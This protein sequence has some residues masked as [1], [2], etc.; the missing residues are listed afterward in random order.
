[1]ARVTIEAVSPASATYIGANLR[2]GDLSEMRAVFGPNVPVQEMAYT[3]ADR[4]APWSYTAK[5]DGQPVM[6]FGVMVDPLLPHL[7]AAWGFGTRHTRRVIPTVTRFIKSELIPALMAH[8]L[9][10]VEV[11]AEAKHIEA[12]DWIHFDL[13]ARHEAQLVCCGASG[14]DFQQLSWTRKPT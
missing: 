1:M 9:N 13:G 6:L 12:I 10:R 14:E 2:D 4:S 11:R 5:L 3:I 8:G 7:G